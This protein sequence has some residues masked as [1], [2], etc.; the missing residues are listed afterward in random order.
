MIRYLIAVDSYWSESYSTPMTQAENDE[1]V[2]QMKLEIM[3]NGPIT[4]SMAVYQNFYSW[5]P[6]QGIP[7]YLCGKHFSSLS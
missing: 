5:K 3:A 1:S 4:A 7:H 6:S 2:A